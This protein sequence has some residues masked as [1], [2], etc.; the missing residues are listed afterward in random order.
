[1]ERREVAMLRQ[2]AAVLSAWL[3]LGPIAAADGQASNPHLK[4][5]IDAERAFSSASG[6]KGVREAFLLYLA[7]DS[8]V[9]RPGPIPGRKAYED[10]PPSSTLLLTWAPEYAEV[11]AG[12]DIGYTTGPYMARDRAKPEGSA[13]YGHY[14]SIWE[15]QANREWKV[16]L[17]AGVRHPQSGPAPETVATLPAGYRRWRGPRVDRD[18]ERTALLEE[19]SRF[20]QSARAEGLTE[21]YGRFAAEDIRVYRDGLLPVKCKTA[22]LKLLAGSTRK[23]S[24]GPVDAVVSATGDLGYVFGGRDGMSMDSREPFEASS[25]VRIWR[26]PAGGQWRIILDLAVPIPTGPASY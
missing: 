8:V 7:D 9:F 6:E 25:Y 23:Y 14:V 21:A 20:A 2:N 3:L 1:M 10:M 18:A 24:W 12:G 5:L 4:R 22:F 19:E 15:R 16:S 11:S 13:S 26:K 17:D